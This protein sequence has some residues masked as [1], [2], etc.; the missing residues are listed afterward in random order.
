MSTIL[1]ASD[2]TRKQQGMME[3]VNQNRFWH[4]S[5]IV[6]SISSMTFIHT[7]SPMNK[8]PKLLDKIFWITAIDTLLQRLSKRSIAASQLGGST[9]ILD[10]TAHLPTREDAKQKFLDTF[11]QKLTE[12][13]LEKPLKGIAFFCQVASR[14]RVKLSPKNMVGL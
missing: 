9:K 11:G 5:F 6:G 1:T 2:T 10:G 3:Q 13:V 4:P 14:Q 8:R 12:C 7:P